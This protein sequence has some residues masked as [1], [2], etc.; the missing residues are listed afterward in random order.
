MAT[1]EQV[2][3]DIEEFKPDLIFISITNATIYDDLDFINWI[4]SFHDCKFVIKGAIF[5]NP[6]K[7]LLDTLD[8]ENVSSMV[9]GEIEFIMGPL[10]ETA[11]RALVPKNWPAKYMSTALYKF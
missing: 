9:G 6:K 10:T 4:K 3:A 1:K 7:S 5:Y 11:A 2:K 8:L